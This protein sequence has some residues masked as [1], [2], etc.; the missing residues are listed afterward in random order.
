MPL[1]TDCALLRSTVPIRRRRSAGGASAACGVVG[2]LLLA[3]ANDSRLLAIGASCAC[4][5]LRRKRLPCRL[6][7]ASASPSSAPSLSSRAKRT[8]RPG[9]AASPPSKQR[10]EPLRADLS[11]AAGGLLDAA[12]EPG[13]ASS[14]PAAEAADAAAAASGSFPPTASMAGVC[15][16]GG[17]SS[18]GAAC[19]AAWPLGASGAAASAKRELQAAG[20]AA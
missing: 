6:A 8:P 3:A 20:V 16:F 15:F 12:T 19:E 5:A 18:G 17:V 11:V 14:S 7:P 4:E 10:R 9:V 2:S 13:E 1:Q